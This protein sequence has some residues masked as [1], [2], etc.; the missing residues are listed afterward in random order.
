MGTR[1]M[2]LFAVLAALVR[3][4]EQAGDVAVVGY[5]PEW[6]YEGANFD[7]MARTYTHLLLFSLEV[8]PDGGIGALDRVPRPTILAKARAAARAHGMA[9]MICFGG[10]GRSAGFSQ[11]VRRPAARRRF[12]GGLVALCLDHGLDGVDYNWEYPGYAFGRGYLPEPEIE[13]DYA[14]LAALIQETREAFAASE[15]LGPAAPISLAYYPDG[16]QERLLQKSYATGVAPS[17]ESADLLHAM[18]YDT[19]G[20][21]GHSSLDYGK[22]CLERALSAGL[23]PHKVTLGLP[24]YGRFVQGGDWRSYEDLVQAHPP[25]A[26]ATD[27]VAGDGD[28]G[29]G[30]E[31]DQR[32]HQQQEIAFNGRDTIAAKTE[33]ALSRGAGGL[34]V[35]E[36]GQD[37]RVEAVSHEDRPRETHGVTCP[38]PGDGSSLLA[39]LRDAIESSPSGRA[40]AAYTGHFNHTLAA[41]AAAVAAREAEAEAAGEAEKPAMKKKKKKKRKSPAARAADDREL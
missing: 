6:R 37:C 13:A 3:P 34:M 40:R 38:G 7:Y 12:V 33:Y 19:H 27:R 20:P 4:T 30:G 26:P 15:F 1:R 2:L 11:M 23:P 41:A 36:A 32:Q 16:R 31:V 28:S 10:N 9:L 5:L 18:A 14:G 25:L 24:F 39:A 8:L 29:D 22:K 35:W 21:E 17:S